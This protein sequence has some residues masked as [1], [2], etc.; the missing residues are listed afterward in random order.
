[1][2][3]ENR[4]TLV[5]LL[6]TI[7]VIAILAGMLLPALNSVREKARELSCMN[8][9]KQL[10]LAMAQYTSAHNDWLVPV[11][12]GEGSEYSVDIK[13]R[14]WIG[15]LCGY[16]ENT[17]NSVA[18]FAA[19]GLY[20]VAWGCSSP[21]R[22]G[23]FSCPSDPKLLLWASNITNYH[24]N[25]YL[26]GGAINSFGEKAGNSRKITQVSMP[27]Q[28][29]SLA[30]GIKGSEIFLFGED[31]SGSGSPR[32]INYTRHASK[33]NFLFID[34]HVTSLHYAK[35]MA[36]PGYDGTADRILKAGY[37]P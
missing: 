6:V 28:S 32:T 17:P 3:R 16:N 31:Y 35:A 21:R 12:N 1:M 20:G 14:M 8:N 13:Y 36:T 29:V 15:M 4:F 37:R 26:H 33:A 9:Q 7:A 10:G 24:L 18:A 30:E 25:A 11:W 34:G 19:S 23:Q 2:N 22:I 5:E 27:S